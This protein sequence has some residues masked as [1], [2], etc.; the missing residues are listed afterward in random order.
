M[1]HDPNGA[2][3]NPG[4]ETGLGLLDIQTSMQASK[5]L[6]QT[7]G[8]HLESGTAVAGYEI[9]VGKTEGADA[10]RPFATTEFGPDGATNTSGTISG[11]YIHGLFTSDAFRTAWLSKLRSDHSASFNYEQTVEDALDQLAASL[12]THLNIDQLL[13]DAE[14]KY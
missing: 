11:T 1:L 8:I 9:H 2:D 13:A 14:E 12:E 5:T 6:R 10:T 7:N 3:G 4:T